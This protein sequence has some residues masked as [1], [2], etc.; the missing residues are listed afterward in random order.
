MKIASSKEISQIEA[1][2]EKL[3]ITAKKLIENAGLKIAENIIKEIKN[4][5][6]TTIIVLVGKGNNGND[7]LIAASHLSSFGINVVA[8]LCIKRP[9]N[10]Y[11]L[12]VA[13]NGNVIIEN[14]SINSTKQLKGLF[15]KADIVIDAILGTGNKRKLSPPISD[16]LSH[17][18]LSKVKNNKLKI[19]AIDIPSGINPDSG[20][21]DSSCV[22]VDKTFILGL[23]KIG[24]FENP[25]P[26]YYGQKSV[27]DIG[28]PI[29]ICKNINYD[30][31]TKSW[32]KKYIPKRS[33]SASKEDFGK[34]LMIVGSKDYP[35]AAGLAANAAMRS[36]AGLV[37][38]GLTESIKPIVSNNTIESVFLTLPSNKSGNIL[39]TKAIKLIEKK[40]IY[41]NVLLYGCGIS[42]S[43]EMENLT[44]LILFSKINFPNII[45][46]ADG[47]NAL[48]KLNNQGVRWWEN[49][50]QHTILTPH[51][52][53]M[54][55]LTGIEIKD[56][57][58]NRISI[59]LKFAKIWNK[60][61]ILKG[62]NTI[63]AF[64]DK[65]LMVSPFATPLLATA[66]TGDVLAGLIAGLIAQ[67][68]PPHIAAGVG[69]YIHGEAAILAS[70]NLKV[71]NIIASDLNLNI[72]KIIKS[73]IES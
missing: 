6:S 62:P 8:Y 13:Q 1:D 72:P 9:S 32:V 23:Y 65:T 15:N 34:V 2:S 66:G 28:L 46:D 38:I 42:Q 55:R 10:D 41:Q 26:E 68:L 50:P 67:K 16:I 48:A 33:L 64:P 40:I 59:S 11:Y 45:I 7:G 61:V 58:K 19:I 14:Y 47:L 25:K 4:I 43:K 73:I 57:Q 24:M 49:I 44:K 22:Q 17:L 51:I 18:K 36:G 39:P 52:K 63:I 29:N 27:L 70:H 71:N 30:L 12:K 37:T 69:V 31:I 3:G 5:S 21:I 56:I 60:I 35:G 20:L 54:S 53:E